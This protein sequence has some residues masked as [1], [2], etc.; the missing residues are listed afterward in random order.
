MNS[1]KKFNKKVWEIFWNKKI[2]NKILFTLFVLAIYRLLVFIPVP[3]ADISV[4]M[5]QTLNS[6]SDFG[7]FVMLLWWALDQFSFIAIWISPYITASIIMQLLWVVLPS[8]EELTEQGEVWHAK[9][10]QYTRYLTF[11]LAFLQGIGSV[12][13]INSMLG[14]AAISTDIGTVLLAGFVMAVGS[15]ILMWMWELITE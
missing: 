9:I 6:G 4:L 10:N 8:V 1:L 11:P 3:F 12:Y 2:R 15:I 5:S 13:L 7:Y 14:W